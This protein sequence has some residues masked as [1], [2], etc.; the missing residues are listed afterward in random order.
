M[1]MSVPPD[2]LTEVKA[3]ISR[4]V[5][6]TTISK[7][8][9]QSLLGKLFWVARVV[10]YAR[11][12]MGR[13]LEQLRSLSKVHDG[14]KVTFSDESK[15]DVRWWAEYLEHFNGVTM[16]VNEDPIM[17][18]YE[19]LL[20]YPYSVCAGDATP[21]GAGAWYGTEYWCGDLPEWLLDPAIPIHLK[22]FWTIIVSAKVWGECW[23]GQ[24]IMVF[25]DNDAVCDTVTHRKPRDQALL[26]LLREFLYLV[27]TMKFFPVVRKIGT[28]T[29]EIA[30]HISRY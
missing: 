21:S 30:D 1:Q 3:D 28:K 5:R 25:C 24:S 26:S 7:R 14:K 17:L 22:E 2:K 9:L 12:F 16:I 11:A 27:V 18:S 23:S 4:W 13:L 10:K 6:K 20:D 8:E 19:Q 15:K 29:N